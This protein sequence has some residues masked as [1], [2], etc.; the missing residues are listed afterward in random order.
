M[1]VGAVPKGC[2]ASIELTVIKHKYGEKETLQIPLAQL[3]SVMGLTDGCT[4]FWGVEEID[5]GNIKGTLF[6]YNQLQGYDH[7][8]RISVP[9]KEIGTEKSYIKRKNKPLCAHF[10]RSKP[11]RTIQNK[12]TR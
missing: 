3:Q 7:V 4:S 12:I 5:G 6:F 1:L 9:I 8:L 10:K 2:E 11:V